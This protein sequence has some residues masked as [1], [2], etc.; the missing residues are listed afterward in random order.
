MMSR[1]AATVDPGG[2][3]IWE[4]SGNSDNLA[5]AQKKQEESWVSFIEQ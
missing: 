3:M 1:I 4:K 5:G 2:R